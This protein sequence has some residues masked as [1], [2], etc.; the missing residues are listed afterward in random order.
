MTKPNENEPGL[1]KYISRGTEVSKDL[2]KYVIISDQEKRNIFYEWFSF[3]MPACKLYD[4]VLLIDPNIKKNF[5]LSYKIS[6]TEYKRIEK[7]DKIKLN[8]ISRN[9]TVEIRINIPK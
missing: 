1:A 9:H 7:E 5:D 2:T 4:F 3:Q 6:K 8:D